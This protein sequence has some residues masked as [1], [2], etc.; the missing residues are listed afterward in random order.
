M[1]AVYAASP[2][3][4]PPKRLTIEFDAEDTA[5]VRLLS[6]APRT[7]SEALKRDGYRDYVYAPAFERFQRRLKDA[8]DR[9][10]VPSA[11]E[12]G[13]MPGGYAK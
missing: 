11:W 2:Q 1:N 3:P 7:F 6:W 4:E 5:M 10:D 12:P 8:L 13:I 9:A